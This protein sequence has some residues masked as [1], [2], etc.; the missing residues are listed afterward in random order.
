MMLRIQTWIFYGLYRMNSDSLWFHPRFNQESCTA[1]ARRSESLIPS[2]P[3]TRSS[4]NFRVRMRPVDPDSLPSCRVRGSWKSPW[5]SEGIGPQAGSRAAQEIRLSQPGR[6]WPVTG[7]SGWHRMLRLAGS[8]QRW[9]HH[10]FAKGWRWRPN[11]MFR[12]LSLS[13]SCLNFCFVL[14]HDIC[15]IDIWHIIYVI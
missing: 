9:Q 14:I 7:S 2:L 12:S 10:Y 15:D 3:P 13:L 6:Q 5:G 1:L 11:L 8:G 4:D